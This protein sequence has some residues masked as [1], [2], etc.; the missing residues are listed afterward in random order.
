ML[1]RHDEDRQRIASVPASDFVRDALHAIMRYYWSF[2]FA[3]GSRIL[4][5]AI[6]AV[7]LLSRFWASAP[8]V[9]LVM[10]DGM[11]DAIIGDSGSS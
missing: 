5:V 3:Q 11:C 9:R 7:W 1:D 8:K 2:N 6:A 10:L 4:L